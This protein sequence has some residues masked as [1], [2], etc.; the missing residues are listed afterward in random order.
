[1]KDKKKKEY[2][3]MSELLRSGRIF[4]VRSMPT[5]KKWVLRDLERRNILRTIVVEHAGRKKSYFFTKEYV[6]DY[7]NAF[8]NGELDIGPRYESKD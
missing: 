8:H 7:V 1:M 4:W 3:N 5:L 6:E 2:I